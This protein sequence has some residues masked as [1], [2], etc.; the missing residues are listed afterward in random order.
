MYWMDIGTSVNTVYAHTFAYNRVYQRQIDPLGQVWQNP[1]AGQII[2]FRQLSRTYG[3][4][5]VSWWD[6]QQASAAG[7]GAIAVGAGNLSGVSAT[8]ATPILKLHSA[9]D[10]VVWAQEHLVSAG[11]ATA[12]D[13]SYGP[14]T[15]SAVESFQA[16]KGL[17]VD[18]IVGPSTWAALL[19][20]AAAPVTWT[21]SG[22]VLATAA[23]VRGARAGRSLRLAVPASARLPARRDEIAGAG[24]RG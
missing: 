1:P 22:A 17:T 2:R 8:A 12:V 24:G 9:G 7:W 18:G 16:A 13:G 6:W 21:H 20:Y 19:Q 14:G 5:G 4:A 10:E 23:A 15:Q 3:A 11:Y